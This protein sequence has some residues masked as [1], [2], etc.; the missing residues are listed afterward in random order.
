MATFG[1][2]ARGADWDAQM[3]RIKEAL[4]GATVRS[5]IIRLRAIGSLLPTARG[6]GIDTLGAELQDVLGDST[7][8]D[9]EFA[10]L[11][12][13]SYAAQMAGDDETAY[14]LAVRAAALPTQ[15]REGA[16]GL[17]L[18]TAIWNGNLEH[19]R[20]AAVV[21]EQGLS[22]GPYSRAFQKAATAA[23]AFLD[24]RTAEAVEMTHEAVAS[25]E[26]LGVRVDAGEIALD[27]L[28][29]MPGEPEIRRL[30]EGYRPLF[31]QLGMKP[32]LERL[33]ATLASM[34]LGAPASTAIPV[35]TP[36]AG[37]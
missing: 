36:T 31:E 33:D 15:S 28:I 12:A 13:T 10:V 16:E 25:L 5:D 30:A 20:S 19:V 27:A 14:R 2:R 23:L 18:R 32:N 35:E 7:D 1:L 37:S 29:L 8:P 9:D 3:A 24:G 11:M 17:V 6:V 26:R 4:E 34:P 21:A 22:T